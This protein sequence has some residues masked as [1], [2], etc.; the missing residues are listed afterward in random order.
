MRIDSTSGFVCVR[1]LTWTTENRTKV[2]GR[3][4]F[5]VKKEIPAFN[6]QDCS[7]GVGAKS[8]RTRGSGPFLLGVNQA[9]PLHRSV[10]FYPCHGRCS[11][12]IARSNLRSERYFSTHRAARP[13]SRLVAHETRRFS[14]CLRGLSRVRKVP[15]FHGCAP[16]NH[17]HGARSN[18]NRRRG[19]AAPA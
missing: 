14:E 4:R 7:S 1:Y 2:G 8:S 13:V 15:L 5:K 18:S 9:N 19:T 10:G 12:S 17:R 11:I 3:W 16:A 6:S